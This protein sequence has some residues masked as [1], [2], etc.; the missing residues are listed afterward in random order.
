M[1]DIDYIVF[2]NAK[3]VIEYEDISI[4]KTRLSE[5]FRYVTKGF[6]Q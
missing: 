1:T 5:C 3:E 6:E 2:C 4:F